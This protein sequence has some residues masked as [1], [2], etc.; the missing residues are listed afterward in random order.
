MPGTQQLVAA[1]LGKVLE[2]QRAD[3]GLPFVSDADTWCTA[4]AGV[5]LASVGTVPEV[6]HR[7]AG[8][9]VRQ[10][11]PAGGGLSAHGRDLHPALP[12]APALPQHRSGPHR[13]ARGSSGEW[14]VSEQAPGGALPRHVGFVP[15]GNR[16]WARQ[17]GLSVL[18]GHR[19]GARVTTAALRWCAAAGIDRVTVWALSLDNVVRRPEVAG[20]LTAIT[21]LADAVAGQ[22]G[23]RLHVIGDLEQLPDPG[24]AEALR[25]AERVSAGD[26]PGAV[27]LAVA[28]DGRHEIVDAARSL[29]AKDPA[30]VLDSRAVSQELELR[31]QSD[32]DL[33][34]RTSGE[35]RLS[36]FLLWQSVPAELYFTDELWPD[37][38]ERSFQRALASY[39][40]R[41]RRFGA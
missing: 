17:Q 13:D 26:G 12:G 38:T 19:R 2:H 40:Q 28:Y 10:Q 21:E 8:H 18:E 3:G 27:S 41:E 29:L 15:D 1:G 35:F 39:A 22:P 25:G 4:T 24:C 36:G 7:L 30:A 9:L 14:A 34:I 23:W 6:L 31:H 5:A 20:M 33:I 11:L 37:F 16:R 32:C